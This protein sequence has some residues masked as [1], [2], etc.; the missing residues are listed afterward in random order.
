[1][2][3]SF[4][5]VT[6]RRG[7]LLQQCLDS[8][9][10]Q[11]GLPRPFEVIV[12]DNAGDAQVTPPTD[13]EIILHV[14]RSPENL[15]VTGGRNKGIALAKGE[16]LIFIDDDAIWH[17][18]TDVSALIQ[19]FATNPKCAATAV[20]SLSPSGQ[21]VALEIP[22][23]DKQ[24]AYRIQHASE[25]PYFVGVGH[26]LRASVIEEVGNYP[27]RYFYA[28]EEIDLSLRI[29]DAGYQIIYQPSVAVI[30]YK[31]DLG[32]PVHGIKYWKNNALNKNRVAWRLLPF[33]YPLTIFLIWSAAAL[34]KTC[35]PGV[36]IDIWRA[37]WQE[38]RLLAEERRPIRPET[39]RYIKSIGGRL[40]Y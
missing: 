36:V 35:R 24:Y 28:M 2:Q 1:M 12:V 18:S 4:I 27:S 31:T 40:L 34:V 11:Q 8:I 6:Y 14:E 9:Y 19:P 13:P 29:L 22:Y 5:V 20:K 26:A 33:P 10:A 23:S 32:R 16:I 21:V 39:V 17:A 15:G 37:L 7:S 30:H 25:A 3:I 38:R